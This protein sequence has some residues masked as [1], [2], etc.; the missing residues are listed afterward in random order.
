MGDSRS[1]SE[2]DPTRAMQ[3]LDDSVDGA[4]NYTILKKTVR[5][6]K[7]GKTTIKY[8]TEKVFADGRKEL[9]TEEVKE[10]NE[11]DDTPEEDD[12]EWK[13]WKMKLQA[14]GMEE[15]KENGVSDNEDGLH[16]GGKAKG[17]LRKEESKSD[18]DS[19]SDEEEDENAKQF[20][21]LERVSLKEHNRLRKLHGAPLLTLN[22]QMC[23]Y[24]TEWAEYLANSNK[25]QHRSENKYGENIYTCWS[26]RPEKLNA[27]APIQSWYD[28]IKKHTFNT[29]PRSTGTGHFTQVVW[30][31]SRELGIG[32]ATKDGRTVVVA[33]YYPPGNF[34]GKY[35][36]NVPQLLQEQ[37]S[38]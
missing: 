23:E 34:V 19:S 11:K 25:F 32:V 5:S 30:K 15:G 29:E 21:R 2:D 24:A 7:N 12:K 31:A 13:E 38:V 1:G 14:F 6:T 4:E 26:S 10:C 18:S 17:R 33:N 3:P 16:E 36:A 27:R 22:K 37:S 28:E 9:L 35:V 20:S 8:I